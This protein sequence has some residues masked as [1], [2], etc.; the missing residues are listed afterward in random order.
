MGQVCQSFFLIVSS[1]RCRFCL[2]LKWVRNSYTH[3]CLV[4]KIFSL[5]CCNDTNFRMGCDVQH[6][7]SPSKINCRGDHV[8]R[9]SLENSRKVEFC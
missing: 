2:D 5:A 7:L 6:N 1:I 9:R 3:S 8:R 4:E